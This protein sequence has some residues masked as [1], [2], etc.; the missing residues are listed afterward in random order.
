M[1]HNM[2]KHDHLME[3]GTLLKGQKV[4][5]LVVTLLLVILLIPVSSMG[6]AKEVHA[7]EVVNAR[8]FG[9]RPGVQQSQTDAIHAAMRYFYDRGVEG[10][11]YL[12]AGTYSVDSALRFHQ[13]VNLVGDGVGRTIIKKVGSQNNYVVGN[14][15]FRGGTTNLN[16]TVSHIT[17]DADRTNRAS[18]GLG[19]VGGMNIDALVSN[20]TLE[21]IEVRDATIGLLVRRL[22]DSVISDSLIDRTS[23]HGIATGSEAHAIGD[24]RNV[25]ITNNRI[26]NSTGGSGINLSRATNT[27]VTYN[28]IIN[29]QQQSDSYGGIR[30]PNGGTNNVVHNNVVEN[31]PRGL[32]LTTGATYNDIYDNTIINSRIHGALIESNNNII[33]GNV[34]IQ[35]NPSLNPESV[36][37]L[38]GANGNSIRYNR[39]ETHRGFNN[40]GIRLTNSS[41]NAVINNITDTTGTPVSIEGG[42][43]NTNN[44]NTNR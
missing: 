6:V 34:F 43:G 5:H 33:G 8:D 28:N 13:G 22:R 1:K 32:F 10:T 4:N 14:P 35:N 3:V 37:R 42:S 27:T 23:G 9:A 7:N 12:P 16:V 24:F 25:L 11:V 26:T 36:I 18:Q 38:S 2:F 40:I 17:F 19:Q 21:H 31:Y 39:M 15:I 41:N 44:G 29:A 20:L 30:I